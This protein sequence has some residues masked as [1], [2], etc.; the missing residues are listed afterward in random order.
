MPNPIH[1][2]RYKLFRDMLANVRIANGLLQ[3]EVADKLRKPQSFVSK[4]ERGERRL[5]FPEF[6]E[7]AEVLGINVIDFIKEYKVKLSKL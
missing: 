4:Y 1:D 3:S 5:D 2:S 7:I 6:I